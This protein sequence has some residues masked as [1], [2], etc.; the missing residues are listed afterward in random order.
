[1][2]W[3]QPLYTREYQSAHPSP[4]LLAKEEEMREYNTELLAD[5]MLR[6]IHNVYEDMLARK[7]ASCYKRAETAR[8]LLATT[9]DRTLPRRSD[10]IKALYCIVGQ[11]FTFISFCERIALH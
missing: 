7:W 5:E 8:Q 2:W 9:T 11:R 6:Q 4:K 10:Y 1:L 3:R